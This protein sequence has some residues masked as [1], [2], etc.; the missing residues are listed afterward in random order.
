[1]TRPTE[2]FSARAEH[3]RRYRPG[4]PAAAIELLAARCGLAAAA[5]VA[6]VGSGTGI[7][8]EQLLGRGARV[9]GIEPNDSMRAAAEERLGAEARFRSVAATAEATTLPPASVDLWVAAQAFH[10]FDAARARAEALRV[11]RGQ[12][13]AALLWNER[14]PDPGAFLTEYEALLH[15][16]ALEYATITARRVDEPSMREFLGAAM[17][18]ERFPNQQLLDYAGLEG[19]LLSSSYA[20][21]HG[22]PQHVPMLAGLRT[23]FERHQRNGEIIFPYE[24]R[25]YFAPLAR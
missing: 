17:E 14:P 21:E 1:V 19:R 16:H 20:P 11:L 6:D 4:Y 8:S 9:I 15:R 2:R 25:V 12:A 5:V 18:C 10:W 24:T 22:H 13:W 23:I 7:L 3:Y